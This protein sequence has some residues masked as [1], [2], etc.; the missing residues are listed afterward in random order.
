MTN[1]SSDNPKVGLWRAPNATLS[2]IYTSPSFLNSL[3]ISTLHKNK[4]DSL[5]LW[6]MRYFSTFPKAFPRVAKYTRQNAKRL[7]GNVNSNFFMWCF[8]IFVILFCLCLLL[9]VTV[10]DLFR[11]LLENILRGSNINFVFFLQQSPQYWYHKL[12]IKSKRGN[13]LYGMKE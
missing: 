1:V 10:N 7:M 2:S 4:H 6:G 8:P 3:N 11:S 12:S 13:C 9:C 5:T